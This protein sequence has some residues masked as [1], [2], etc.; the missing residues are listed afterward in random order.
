MISL[1]DLCI[2]IHTVCINTRRNIICIIGLVVAV[3]VAQILPSAYAASGTGL[4]VN[5]I[6][7]IGLSGNKIPSDKK[8]AWVTI[9]YN[10]DGSFGD[11]YAS[12]ISISGR[13]WEITSPITSSTSLAQ[14]AHRTVSIEVNRPLQS[15]GITLTSHVVILASA[16]NTY[17]IYRNIMELP[18]E[19]PRSEPEKIH[20]FDPSMAIVSALGTGNYQ[21]IDGILTYWIDESRYDRHGKWKVDRFYETFK[22]YFNFGRSET[23]EQIQR[24]RAASPKSPAAALAEASYWVIYAAKLRGYLEPGKAPDPD[25]L[26]VIRQYHSKAK[27]IL[28]HSKTFAGN[29]PVWHW[30]RLKMAIDGN[31]GD[32]VVGKAF[33]SAIQAFPQYPNSYITMASHLAMDGGI[34][35]WDKVNEV[36]D[37]LDKATRITDPG[38]YAELIEAVGETTASY[39]PNLYSAR[40]VSWSRA[41][42]SWNALISRYAT[43][44]NMNKFA[45]QA[46]QADDKD[47][48]L[49]LFGMIGSR[50]VPEVWPGNYSADLCRRRYVLKS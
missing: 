21:E 29:T 14:G 40:I 28:D 39:I 3:I 1:F 48:L 38:R 19:W 8:T 34:R 10:Y 7:L 17:P 33:N 49:T 18:I 25:A 6:K 45:A 37:R 50:V 15:E 27:G 44:D 2:E 26:K 43:P 24:W 22:L 4:I 9:D 32:Q 42:E 13:D 41:K 36:A 23:L 12:A 31:M 20:S 46:C 30:L 35:R 47:T 16:R 11:I 5:S